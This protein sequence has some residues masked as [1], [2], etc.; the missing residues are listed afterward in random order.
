M[1]IEDSKA[2]DKLEPNQSLLSTSINEAKDDKILVANKDYTDEN[3]SYKNMSKSLLWLGG[4]MVFTQISSMIRYSL[5]FIFV[6]NYGLDET[7][8]VSTITSLYS[9]ITFGTSWAFS[10]GYGF[11]AAE[12]FG[13]KEFTELG[14]ITNKAIFLNT[15]IGIFLGLLL[16]LLA[17]VFF[18]AFISDQKTLENVDVIFKSIGLSTPL[19]FYLMV[20]TRYLLAIGHITPLYIGTLLS[21]LVQLLFLFIFISKLGWVNLGIG[22]SFT[23]GTLSYTAY[24]YYIFYYK[25]RYPQTILKFSFCEALN[26]QWEFFKYSL[27]LFGLLFLSYITYDL[28]PLLTF[29]VST[30]TFAAYGVILTLFSFLVVFAD[31][32]AVGNNI[33]INQAIGEK[34]TEFIHRSVVITLAIITVYLIIAIILILVFYHNLISLLTSVSSVTA[35]TDRMKIVFLIN[36]FV[37]CYLPIF[38]ESV[39]A[40]GDGMFPLYTVVGGRFIVTLGMSFA[41]IKLWNLGPSSIL[42]SFASG[43]AVIILLNSFRLYQ[44]LS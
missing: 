16:S 35:I 2:L 26:G 22:F 40:V 24:F 1:V 13:K 43:N 23:L 17:K 15:S 29:L 32:I 33:I 11:K 8:A 7:A 6:R 4:T 5:L 21:I 3:Y 30:E 31:S 18:S 9:I 10:Q 39:N 20:F 38:T 25:N 44:I 34:K 14:K 41:L 37:Y 28:L 12:Y 27:P 19:Q 42:I 36:C